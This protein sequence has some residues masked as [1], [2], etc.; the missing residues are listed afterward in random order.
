MPTKSACLKTQFKT[1]NLMALL[2]SFACHICKKKDFP[3]PS[4][5]FFHMDKCR[6]TLRK[7]KIEGLKL[8]YPELKNF[9]SITGLFDAN[10][11]GFPDPGNEI[12]PNE[13][14]LGNHVAAKSREFLGSKGI[15]G[16]VNA[17]WEVSSPLGLYSDLKI[18]SLHLELDDNHTE[19]AVVH[20]DKVIEFI[21]SV[22]GPVLIHCA[23][24]VSRSTTM[25]TA[26]LMK[27][28]KMS[29][30]AAL[31]LVKKNRPI[32]YPN[33]GFFKQ[34]IE[35]EHELSGSTESFPLEMLVLHQEGERGE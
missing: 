18:K 14:F 3:D 20:V 26:Y 2:P 27:H 34:L 11:T 25:L 16:V 13:L 31:C 9:D 30:I 6:E 7:E 32:I 22:D 19:K 15:R 4:Q 12:L 23:A 10:S 8:A 29:L 33:R 5:L 28:K 1:K 24:G 17:A 21:K 35:L